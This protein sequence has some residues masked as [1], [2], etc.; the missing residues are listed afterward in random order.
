VYQK[1]IKNFS[2]LGSFLRAVPLPFIT[3]MG[4][5]ILCIECIPLKVS[6]KKGDGLLLLPNAKTKWKAGF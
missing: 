3:S 6:S 5:N 2:L 4:T 1:R